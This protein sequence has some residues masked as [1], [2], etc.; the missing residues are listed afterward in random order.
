MDDEYLLV[1]FPLPTVIIL[2]YGMV[3][4]K[5]V[6]FT[7]CLNM[8]DMNSLD[9]YLY[10]PNEELPESYLQATYTLWPLAAELKPE[11]APLVESSDLES[12][13]GMSIDEFVTFILDNEG[14]ANCFN[15]Y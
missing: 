9:L 12:R 15:V 4:G 5:G 11:D 1:Y 8:F 14:D 3:F 13:T 6:H 10:D 2:T 7:M